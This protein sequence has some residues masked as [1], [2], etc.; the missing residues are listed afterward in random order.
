MEGDEGDDDDDDDIEGGVVEGDD[1]E[2]P[3][4][5]VLHELLG[6][7]RAVS[8][9]THLLLLGGPWVWTNRETVLLVFSN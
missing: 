3:G 7:G 4:Q 5:A 1:G 2:A 8:D 6:G 9:H